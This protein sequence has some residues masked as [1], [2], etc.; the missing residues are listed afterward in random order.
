MVNSGSKIVQ[1]LNGELMVLEQRKTG[2]YMPGLILRKYNHFHYSFT[3][4][5][6]WVIKTERKQAFERPPIYVQDAYEL[7]YKSYKNPV[8]PKNSNIYQIKI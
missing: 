2:F 3:N 7:L 6:I 1:N 5:C 4:N 8:K